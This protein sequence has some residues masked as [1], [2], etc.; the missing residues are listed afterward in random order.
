MNCYNDVLEI[1]KKLSNLSYP[2]S[3]IILETQK[4]LDDENRLLTGVLSN[5]SN[6]WFNHFASIGKFDQVFPNKN[7]IFVSQQVNF[8]DLIIYYC[9]FSFNYIYY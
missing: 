7:L 2:S 6:N 1:I 8:I 5:H 3:K 9:L 4:L